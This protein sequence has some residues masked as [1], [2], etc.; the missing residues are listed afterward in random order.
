NAA[1]HVHRAR[2]GKQR[3]DAKDHERDEQEVDRVAP[4]DRARRH[5]AA[6]RTR[7]ATRTASTVSGTSWVRMS[8]APP[9]TAA[10]VAASEAGRRA[11]G[12]SRPV[13]EPKN[14]LRETPTQSRRPRAA[15]AGNSAS[16]A[17]SHAWHA[18]PVTR[19][20]RI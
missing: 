20:N 8:A 3:E 15:S 11:A 7:S 2:P 4:A 1:E 13:M 12:S 14:D 10:V 16:T 6:L 5:R 19:K 17:A 18:M 9:S